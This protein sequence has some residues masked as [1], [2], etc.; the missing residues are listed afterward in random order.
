MPT[1][2]SITQLQS[3]CHLLLQHHFS[4]LNTY[5]VLVI[6]VWN[7][8]L[9][10]YFIMHIPSLKQNVDD[11]KYKLFY[12]QWPRPFW[13]FNTTKT[14]IWKALQ[15]NGDTKKK[16]IKIEPK[17]GTLKVFSQHIARATDSPSLLYASGNRLAVAWNFECTHVLILYW[18]LFFLISHSL[19]D[20]ISKI[21]SLK[22]V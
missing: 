21:S 2:W 7:T 1:D 17:V 6:I 20:K 4:F 3:L 14:L 13:Y 15:I 8:L 9:Q 11:A 18:S 12:N 5:F 10:S 19:Q 16:N 22:C